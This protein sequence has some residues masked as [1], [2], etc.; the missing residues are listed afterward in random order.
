MR[1]AIISNFFAPIRTG[2]SNWAK[3]LAMAHA[4]SGDEVVVITASLE[5]RNEE[6]REEEGY[7]IYRLK[8]SIRLP[9]LSIFMNFDQFHLLGTPG[10][11]RRIKDILRRHEIQVVHQSNHLLDSPFMTAMACRS[12]GL[13]SLCSVMGKI[14]HQGNR[15][16][17][18]LL[19]TADRLC[20]RP[21]MRGYDA[22]LAMDREAVDYVRGTYDHPWIELLPFC[23]LWRHQVEKMPLADPGRPLVD[24]QVRIASVGH[25]TENRNRLEMVRALPALIRDGFKPHLVIA[26]K[27]LTDKPR[28]EAR[29]LGVEHCVEFT[30][31][32]SRERMFE[33]LAG[34]HIEGHLFAYPGLGSATE[35][36]MAIGLPVLANGYEGIYG[37]VPF[38]NESN[39][40]L[41]SPEDQEG[42]DRALLRLAG[43]DALRAEMG[44]AARRL[45]LDHLVWETVIERIRD[46]CL[47][48]IAKKT[49]R[50]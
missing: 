13:P 38:R 45:V 8:P 20:L 24:R 19:R 35:E 44:A 48:I 15:V 50:A 25:V 3:E 16:Y 21:M 40:M 26:G 1:L 17:D 42:V 36:A 41:V 12:L 31:E 23:T 7:T 9:N 39:I 18:L 6:P 32:V 30:G 10:N 46:L 29:A 28:A 37:D 33:I 22:Q 5:H 27:E 47:R 14:T 2:S 11:Y 49:A 43:D 4:R 34:A